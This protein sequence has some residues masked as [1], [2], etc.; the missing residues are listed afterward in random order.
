MISFEK[1]RLAHGY[2]AIYGGLVLVAWACGFVVGFPPPWL[3]GDPP[4]R[5]AEQLEFVQTCLEWRAMSNTSRALAGPNTAR[6]CHDYFVHRSD[7]DVHRIRSPSAWG[8]NAA[9][10]GFQGRSAGAKHALVQTLLRQHA[11]FL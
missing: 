8:C 7:E 4:R 5:S 1:I 3:K 11:Y 9:V 10:I 2:T 6:D